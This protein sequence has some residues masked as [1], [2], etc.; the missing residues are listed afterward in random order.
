VNLYVTASNL[1]EGAGINNE[2]GSDFP[3]D[4]LKPKKALQAICCSRQT[5][6]ITL[7]HHSS[8]LILIS[9]NFSGDSSGIICSIHLILNLK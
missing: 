7:G 9:T 5:D 8:L 4:P 6:S 1:V 2:V 3:E